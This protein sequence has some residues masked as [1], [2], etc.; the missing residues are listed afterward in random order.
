MLLYFCESVVFCVCVRGWTDARGVVLG[1]RSLHLPQ[2]NRK[3]PL[4]QFYPGELSAC[5]PA[6]IDSLELSSPE[7]P[8]GA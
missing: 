8:L 2:T 7:L 3:I 4:Q 5:S 1:T 6:V